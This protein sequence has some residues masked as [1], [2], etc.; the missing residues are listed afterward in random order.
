MEKENANSRE[1]VNKKKPC[2]KVEIKDLKKEKRLLLL[3]K[4]LKAIL[5]FQP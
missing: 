5:I 4:V 1:N 2:Q 3:S